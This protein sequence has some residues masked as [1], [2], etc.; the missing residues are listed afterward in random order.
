MYCFLVQS[1]RNFAPENKKNNYS[2]LK[3]KQYAIQ[4][5]STS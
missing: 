4:T 5:Y 1:P 3:N 2:L